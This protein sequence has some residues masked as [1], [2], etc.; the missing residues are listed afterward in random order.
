MF[1]GRQAN[2]SITVDRRFPS[3][4]AFSEV[5]SAA[6]QQQPIRYSG[7]GCPRHQHIYRI[8]APETLG[9][10]CKAR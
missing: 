2:P 8:E 10:V 7:S 6:Q 5:P 3:R 4:A 9:Q 1:K